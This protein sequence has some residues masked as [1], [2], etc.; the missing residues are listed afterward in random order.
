M[1][2]HETPAGLPA[3]EAIILD[4]DGLLLDSETLYCRA[5]Q[6]AASELGFELDESLLEGLFGCHADAVVQSLADA[7]GPDF[8]RI[9]FFAAAET[10]WFREIHR[11]GIPQMPGVDGLLGWIRQRGIPC[12]VAT[13]SDHHYARLC[14]AQGGLADAFTTVLTRDQVARGK[15]EPDLFLAAAER[16]GVDPARCVVLEDSETGLLAANAAGA[17]PVLI[18]PRQRLRQKFGHHALVAL[19][20]LMEFTELVQNHN[21]RWE[22]PVIPPDRP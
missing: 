8:N 11:Q 14:L 15:P 16:L 12:A 3:F 19:S 17:L 2:T 22:T 4:M 1:H 21:D 6:A 18:Q 13:N 5:W 10:L 7:L 20:S 9:T